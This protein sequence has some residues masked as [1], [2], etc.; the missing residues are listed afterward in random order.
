MKKIITFSMA[1]LLIV[2]VTSSSKE[3]K[4]DN[5]LSGNTWNID[6]IEW[7]KHESTLVT[8][9]TETN[10]GTFTFS[11]TTGSSTMRINGETVTGAE[12]SWDAASDGGQVNFRY[13]LTIEGTTTTQRAMAIEENKKK[14]QIWVMTEQ[15]VDVSTGAT[16]QLIATLTLSK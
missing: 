8:E 2:A 6:K 11:E 16:F 4:L 9:G 13:S 10:A 7:V 12:F 14:S 1:L 15:R 3:K 5:W